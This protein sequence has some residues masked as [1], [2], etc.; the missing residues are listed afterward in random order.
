MFPMSKFSLKVQINHSYLDRNQRVNRGYI[1]C[2]VY[3]VY[4]V[5]AALLFFKLVLLLRISFKY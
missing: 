2:T 4:S 5:R 1:H 3:T